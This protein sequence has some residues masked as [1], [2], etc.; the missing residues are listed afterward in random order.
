MN[1][2][3]MRLK[4]E[5]FGEKKQLKKLA[6]FLRTIQHLGNVGS[7]RTLKLWIDGD[8]ATRM[9]FNFP[10]IKN[11]DEISFLNV[12]SEDKKEKPWIIWIE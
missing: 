5:A 1:K 11:Q 9:K 3:K 6:S 2:E 8:G 7:T 10:D 12:D 4:I